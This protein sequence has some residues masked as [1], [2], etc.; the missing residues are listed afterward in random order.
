M[1]NHQNIKWDYRQ[2]INKPLQAGTLL[3]SEPFMRDPS[4]I[5]STCLLINHVKTEGTFGF[6]LDKIS[7][8]KLNDLITIDEAYNFDIY[9]GGPVDLNSLF[10]LH[11]NHFNLKNAKKINEN[12]YW[13]GDFDELTMKIEAGIVS[14]SDIKFILG[15]SGWDAEQLRKEIIENSWIV[16]NEHQ[17]NLNENHSDLWK[18]VLLEMGGIYK[19]FIGLPINPNLN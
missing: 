9:S 17:L 4:F 6:I 8:Y 10:Y 11:N 7:E 12:L 18:K 14:K 2:E 16:N 15:Y 1:T 5:R 13:G 3:L 19:S